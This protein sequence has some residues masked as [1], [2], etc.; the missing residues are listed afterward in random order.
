MMQSLPTCVAS[1]LSWTR[2][3]QGMTSAGLV[4]V[5][6]AGGCLPP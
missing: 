6:Y 5:I 3:A 4:D 2:R 1:P